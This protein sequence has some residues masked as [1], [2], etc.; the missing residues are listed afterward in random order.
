MQQIIGILCIF[1]RL[2]SAG[3]IRKLSLQFIQTSTIL[4][5]HQDTRAVLFRV[6]PLISNVVRVSDSYTYIY[7]SS[8][9]HF[10]GFVFSLFYVH[11]K[12]LFFKEEEV[13]F[14]EEEATVI[15]IDRVEAQYYIMS[16]CYPKHYDSNKCDYIRQTKREITIRNNLG[17]EFALQLNASD[18]YRETSICEISAFQEEDQMA[19]VC[20]LLRRGAV[21]VR[22][23]ELKL[24]FEGDRPMHTLDQFQLFV[25]G[26][27]FQGILSFFYNSSSLR[28][29]TCTLVFTVVRVELPTSNPSTLMASSSGDRTPNDQGL[30]ST[31]IRLLLLKFHGVLYVCM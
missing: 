24:G 9:Q 7:V 14:F 28:T 5:V 18:I 8:S 11:L 17:P 23:S 19:N 22:S 31:L 21:I 6:F 30:S 16:P 13:Y 4:T 20:S 2:I 25:S 12:L 10:I 15:D 3:R 26:S 27:C 29:R 1:F